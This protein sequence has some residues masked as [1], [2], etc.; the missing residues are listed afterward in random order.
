[1]SSVVDGQYFQ[2]AIVVRDLEAA[3]EEL[4]RTL[5]VEWGG[6]RESS[7]GEWS[8]RLSFSKQGPPHVELI[9][10][11]PGGPWEVDPRGKMRLD[12]LQWW[13]TD[14]DADTERLVAD[15]AT[16]DFDGMAYDHPFRY[17]K[18][19]TGLRVEL[20]NDPDGSLRADYRTRWHIDEA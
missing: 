19:A 12:H 20:I 1:V 6:V 17:F 16:V 10:A 7:M 8:Y 15:G 14:I 4:G 9:E 5:G 13:T 11:P 2:V 3:R 18:L